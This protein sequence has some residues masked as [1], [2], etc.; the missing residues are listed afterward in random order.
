MRGEIVAMQAAKICMYLCAA[1]TFCVQLTAIECPL[2]R[3]AYSPAPGAAHTV[4]HAFERVVPSPP[5]STVAQ[6]LGLPYYKSG[7]LI[8]FI[9]TP[10][11]IL[12]V[13]SEIIACSPK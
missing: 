4:H 1:I 7:C 12:F 2:P 6:T 10:L 11:F 8:I 13:E 9:P 5:P 3:Q